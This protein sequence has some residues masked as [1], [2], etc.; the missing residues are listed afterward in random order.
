M[1]KRKLPAGP[2]TIVLLA[3]DTGATLV[4]RHVTLTAGDTLSVN[5]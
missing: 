4:E 2:H 1:F 5:Q 3:P